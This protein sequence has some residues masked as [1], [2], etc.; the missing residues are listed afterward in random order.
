MIGI[1]IFIFVIGLVVGSFLNVVI[2]R[3]VSGES[4]V[5]PGSKC[6]KCQNSLKWWHNIP[7]L[8][9]IF[10]RGKC[11]FC[12]EKISIQYPIVELLTGIIFTCFGY[13]YL[14]AMFNTNESIPILTVMFIVSL[15]ASSLFIVI[16]GTDFKEMQVSDAHTYTL[17][18]LGLFYSIII[19]SFAFYGDFKFGIT[20]WNLLFTPIMFTICA[21]GIAFIF[22]EILRRG[23]NFLMKT[24]TF[25]DGDSY[26][27]CGI[28][29]VV[30]SLFG[31]SD[32][33][34]LLIV[35]LILFFSSV[36]LS[37][38]FTLPFYL[39][40][41]FTA[42]NWKLISLISIF[43][44]FSAIL[45][46]A[47]HSYYLENIILSVACI[48]IL[49]ILGLLLCFEILKGIRNNSSNGSQIPFGPSLCASGLIALYALPILLGIV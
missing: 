15:I 7:V 11:A 23:T 22:M 13:L 9:Y 24:E 17:I 16:S 46:Y 8:S 33:K 5:F 39:K 27:F 30:T 44:I 14:N 48:A 40:S 2:L 4:I 26:I 1:L 31:A 12:K 25:G 21:S 43:I 3:T 35:L 28:C 45:F 18:G 42:K 41:L 38:I 6:P 49:I 47:E 37:V 19:G 34:Y 29:G 36:I 20:K 32:V 10:L